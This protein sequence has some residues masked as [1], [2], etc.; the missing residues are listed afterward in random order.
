MRTKLLKFFFPYKTKEDFVCTLDL[1]KP[2]EARDE[3]LHA[4]KAYG[5]VKVV[6]DGSGLKARAYTKRRKRTFRWA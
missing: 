2:V 1:E 3:L 5:V 4:L 6:L